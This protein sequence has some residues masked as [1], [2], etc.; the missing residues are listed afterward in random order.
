MR[1][2]VAMLWLVAVVVGGL[3]V[4][5]AEAGDKLEEATWILDAY[6]LLRIEDHI[7]AEVARESSLWADGA[8]KGWMTVGDSD[9][10]RVEWTFPR[11]TRATG[12]VV[13][14]LEGF[15]A[16]DPFAFIEL[17][18]VWRFLEIAEA[19]DG[20]PDWTRVHEL[21]TRRDPDDARTVARYVLF[22]R[23]Q[24][25]DHVPAGQEVEGSLATL[26][27]QLAMQEFPELADEDYNRVR[28]EVEELVHHL[29]P[30]MTSDAF[31]VQLDAASDQVAYDDGVVG[32]PRSVALFTYVATLHG[33]ALTYAQLDVVQSTSDLMR[34]IH[35]G[36]APHLQE[37]WGVLDRVFGSPVH[38][39]NTTREM[40]FMSYLDTRSPSGGG[41][42]DLRG[43]GARLRAL[44]CAG[45]GTYAPG[46]NAARLALSGA[47][48]GGDAAV[49][50]MGEGVY[51]AFQA[52]M[53]LELGKVGAAGKFGEG[54]VAIPTRNQ[55]ALH[56]AGFAVGVVGGVIKTSISGARR[57]VRTTRAGS[58]AGPWG[59]AAG[60]LVGAGLLVKDGVEL[61][62]EIKADRDRIDRMEERRNEYD[63]AI[64]AAEVE[65][66]R[67]KKE[68]DMAEREAR[69]ARAQGK[70]AEDLEKDAERHLR[71]AEEAKQKQERMEK[72]REKIDKDLA[73]AKAALDQK[74]KQAKSL[75]K[76]NGGCEAPPEWYLALDKAGSVQELLAAS[77]AASGFVN[78]QTAAWLKTPPVS[79]RGGLTESRFT[80]PREAF[81]ARPDLQ[82][83]V[84]SWFEQ[85]YPDQQVPAW[86]ETTNPG[87]DWFIE[88]S[89]PPE[90]ERKPKKKKN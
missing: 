38:S 24:G 56:R 1:S 61:G 6:Y 63:K 74:E 86:L 33:D 68:A 62:Q 32:R 89:R 87:V 18:K 78:E 47:L 60:A 81:A 12:W 7:E 69:D 76:G 75:K 34:Q 48:P 58:V 83:G 4:G 30:A 46:E 82:D 45:F 23:S 43:D 88:N 26:S 40:A 2:T 10:S 25:L 53:R 15:E 55:I 80:I 64:R 29:N 65:A 51:S 44:M 42:P 54:A 73:A 79:D 3:G 16:R 20:G 11:A 72:E 13:D 35:P 8:A 21:L 28:N 17:K 39:D 27:Q 84:R 41:G 37:N 52:K 70:S 5:T 49:Q 9:G 67:T 19:S 50:K 77:R 85:K 57:I 22:L 31:Q 71:E 90:P 66:A 59:A 36:V 14:D